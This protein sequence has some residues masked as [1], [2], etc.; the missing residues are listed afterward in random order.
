MAQ[1]AKLRVAVSDP[2]H[3]LD[4]R[5][6]AKVLTP[7]L[8]AMADETRLT[9]ILLIAQRPRTVKE[10][11]EATGLSQTLVSHH[12]APLREQELIEAVPRG[13][14][15]QYVLCCPALAEPVRVLASLAAM[16]PE[17]VAACLQPRA[18]E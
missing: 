7:K 5:E 2:T 11:Q 4:E 13:R 17:G 3:W 16:D 15:N 10:L 14:S 18:A 9:L 6:R 8:R 1:P 12:L